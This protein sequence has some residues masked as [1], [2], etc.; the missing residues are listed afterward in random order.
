MFNIYI[1]IEYNVLP[2][3][4]KKMLLCIGVAML[5]SCLRHFF[6]LR[7]YAEQCF[8]ERAICEY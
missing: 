4:K 1:A 6:S 2:I 8:K 3:L 7:M 5:K